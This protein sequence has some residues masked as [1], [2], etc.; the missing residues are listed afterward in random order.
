[1]HKTK[2]TIGVTG[3]ERG[4]MAAWLFTSL[5]IRLQGGNPVRLTPANEYAIEKLDALVLGGGADVDPVHYGEETDFNQAGFSKPKSLRQYLI[6]IFSLF[7][8]PLVFLLRKVLAVR[9]RKVDKPRDEMELKYLAKALEKKMPVLGICRGA[10]LLNVKLGGT[11][12]Q[13]ITGFY[14]EIPRIYSV[15]PK[16]EVKVAEDSMLGNILDTPYITVNALH[17]QAIDQLAPSLKVVARE[18][19]G[20][21]QAVESSDF[22]FLLGVQWHPEYMPQIKV[23]RNI[24]SSLVKA[25]RTN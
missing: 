5:A 8:Y 20:I 24:F 23:Q 14:G 3:P 17:H 4:G 2:P 25:A 16:K 19:S 11:L 13:D 1:M 10:Q 9:S 12:Y 7:F 18:Q 21:V 15:F 22:P 6:R